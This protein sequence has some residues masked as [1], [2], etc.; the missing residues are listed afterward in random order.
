[1]YAFNIDKIPKFD[2]SVYDRV[3][4]AAIDQYITQFLSFQYYEKPVKFG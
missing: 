4:V 3:S 2:E 1:M